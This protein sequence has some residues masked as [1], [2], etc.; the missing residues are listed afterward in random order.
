MSPALS[1]M[2]EKIH[3]CFYSLTKLALLFLISSHLNFRKIF[4]ILPILLNIIV[5]LLVIIIP[6]SS[7]S[8]FSLSL[9]LLSLFLS[10]FILS[11]SYSI[12]SSFSRSLSLSSFSLI[13]YIYVPLSLSH[14]KCPSF[15]HS[16]S[17][18]ISLSLTLFVPLSNS[19]SLTNPTCSG[20]V[21]K[22]LPGEEP[23]SGNHY[24][25][26]ELGE[27]RGGMLA[28]L[29]LQHHLQGT[30]ASVLQNAFSNL[31]SGVI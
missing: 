11:L 29:C 9:K 15:S 14:S 13:L 12:Y 17:L 24:G 18:Y 25:W 28:R 10:I 2:E 21:D 22:L 6:L 31:R 3:V 5:P 20:I 16:L 23:G 30:P 8:L 7:R 1:L 26:H 27:E 19:L 4:S